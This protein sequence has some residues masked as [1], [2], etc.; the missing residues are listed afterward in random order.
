MNWGPC[1]D[2]SDV[3]ALLGTIGVCRMFIKNLA[4]QAHHLV[5]LTRKGTEWEFEQK[6]LDAMQDLKEALIT[7]PALRP[8][9]YT[10]GM[11]VILSVD[12]S[13]IAIGH[14]LSQCNPDKPKLRYFMKFG[15]ITLNDRESHFS[16]PKLKLYGLYHAFQAL[17]LYLIGLHNLIVKVNAKYIKGMLAN[18]DIAP[19]TSIN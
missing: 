12:S 11:L 16:Q 1:H 7:S 17:K 4:H 5:R 19:S 6:Q 8:I 18:P 2:L 3:H 14:I 9:N 10:S 15:L 13:H